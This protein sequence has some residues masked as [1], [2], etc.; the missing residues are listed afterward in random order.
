MII[1]RLYRKGSIKSGTCKHKVRQ[2]LTVLERR[3]AKEINRRYVWLATA[4]RAVDAGRWNG[5]KFEARRIKLYELVC[6]CCDYCD[7]PYPTLPEDWKTRG[8]HY[9]HGAGHTLAAEAGVPPEDRCQ[10]AM[11]V[12][13]LDF[14]SKA[15][16]DMRSRETSS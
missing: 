13:T 6:I 7:A 11:N 16:T 12:S 4:C 14:L 5:R 1:E 8:L 2:V 15:L 9:D 10:Y 3:L